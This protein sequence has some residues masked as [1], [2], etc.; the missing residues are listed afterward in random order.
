MLNVLYSHTLDT[1]ARCAPTWLHKDERITSQMK[2]FRRIF[3]WKPGM[4]DWNSSLGEGCEGP[5][6]VIT[7]FDEFTV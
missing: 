2:S 3:T 6:L 5:Q 7:D 4:R 1:S